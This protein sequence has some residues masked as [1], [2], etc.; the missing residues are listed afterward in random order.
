MIDRNKTGYPVMPRGLLLNRD[1]MLIVTAGAISS[2]GTQISQIAL[3]L[4]ALSLTQSP[5]WAGL[6]GATQQLPYLL[7]SLPAGAWVD[8]VS[9]KQLLIV[10]DLVRFT[11]LGSIP[12]AYILGMLHLPQLLFVVFVVGI[13]TVLFEVAELAA[14]PQVVH[15]TQLARA[16]SVSEGINATAKVIGPSMGGFL[17]SLR[18]SLRQTTVSGAVLAYLV[19]SLS[20][21][22]S[23]C[24]LLRVR[25]PL[26][27]PQTK[28]QPALRSALREGLRFLW[29][30]P[31]L[32]ALMIV[33]TI[34]NFLQAP[35]S[36]CVILVAQQRLD[37]SPAQIGL[38]FGA[39]GGAAV[40]SSLL[41][42]W[43]Y[44]PDRL[45]PIMLG[46]LVVWVLSALTL[47]LATNSLTLTLGWALTQ[48]VW[49]VYAVAVVSYR[50]AETPDQLQGRVISAF[51][52]LSYGAESVGLA[53]GGLSIAVVGPSV[54]FGII[55]IGLLP[56]VGMIIRF[57]FGT[58][59]HT[60]LPSE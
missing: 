49:P 3:P 42:A 52:A 8:R 45:R 12:L 28:T 34:V 35:L 60:T 20:Y 7:C 31:T 33:T 47:A 9:R 19:D 41:A 43:V 58:L 10:C 18:I 15:S 2:V 27:H 54:M 36:L 59:S 26:Q 51:R 29:H 25:R 38:I 44:R 1:Y 11:L 21:W 53:L 14:L 23:A 37:L 16:R 17:I 22:L 6:L 48:L 32:R 30:H 40:L 57:P 50:L 13:C 5:A 4:L 39:A 56:C 46:S 24:A 55:G